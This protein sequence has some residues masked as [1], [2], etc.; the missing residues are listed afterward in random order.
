MQTFSNIW[1]LKVCDNCNVE[2]NYKG[3][4]KT[5]CNVKKIFKTLEVYSDGQHQNQEYMLNSEIGS[6]ETK[7][8]SNV[9]IDAQKLHDTLEI[10]TNDGSVMEIGGNK[11]FISI[12]ICTKDE[13]LFRLTKGDM[14][15]MNANINTSSLSKCYLNNNSINYLSV[16][17]RGSSKVFGGFFVNSGMFTIMDN[18]EMTIN[19]HPGA[20][21]VKVFKFGSNMSSRLADIKI[22]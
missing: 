9:K 11:D 4:M 12:H 2:I 6:I 15:I 7:N 13:S 20:S 16:L 18:S 19:C 5:K 21:D 17:S 22:L 10:S 8:L 3:I 14:T 1:K